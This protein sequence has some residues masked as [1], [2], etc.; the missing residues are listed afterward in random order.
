MGV[1]IF[2]FAGE[3]VMMVV[4]VAIDREAF[5]HAGAEQRLIFRMAAHGFRLAFTADVLV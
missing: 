2:H 4:M 3:A 1:T 5:R